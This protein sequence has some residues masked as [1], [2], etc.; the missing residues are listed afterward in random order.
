MIDLQVQNAGHDAQG[1]YNV[2]VGRGEGVGRVSSE[3][4]SRHD[5]TWSLSLSALMAL[6]KGRADR[7]RTR[8]VDSAAV[9]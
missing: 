6:V 9:R 3:W 4:F 1:S 7:S 8:M 5:D 2:D